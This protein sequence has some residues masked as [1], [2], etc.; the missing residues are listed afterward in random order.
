MFMGYRSQGKSRSSKG[1]RK[2]PRDGVA[3]KAKVQKHHVAGQYAQEE[4]PVLSP[5]E[6][7]DKALGRLGKLG[8]QIFAVFPYSQYFDDWLVS[9]GEVLSDFESDPMINVDEEFV[10]T[11][12][13]VLADVERA[14]AERRL[15]EA[16]ADNV[17]K[18]LSDTNHLVADLDADFASK[19]HALSAKRNVEFE[20]E[21]QKVHALEDE[22]TQLRQRK[23]SLLF[24]FTRKAKA[25][26][27]AETTQ[28][29]TVAKKELELA[30]QS[31]DVE[32]EKLHYDYENKKAATIEEV[33]A[34]EKQLEELQKDGSLAERK[35]ACVALAEAVKLFLQRKAVA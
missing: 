18:T 8:T 7:A 14:L 11:R 16:L 24:G 25:Q 4:K 9:L 27:E 2:Q 1:T 32:Q 23:T 22:L 34:L 5:Q 13:G 28:K 33:R 10:K 19:T 12:S 31:F 20:R 26:K 29:L 17:S 3:S 6:I 21:T 30:L 15:G 35:T